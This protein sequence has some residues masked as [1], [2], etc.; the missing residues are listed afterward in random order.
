[1]RSDAIGHAGRA[2]QRRC[3]ALAGASM[4]Q[5]PATS[6]ILGA[7]VDRQALMVRL[8]CCNA[9]FYMCVWHIRR[10]VRRGLP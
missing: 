4:L 7:A 2:V 1:M 10:A 3:V 6:M 8:S 5:T 9:G